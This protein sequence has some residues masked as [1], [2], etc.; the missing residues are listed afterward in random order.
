MSH[1]G[2]YINGN[3]DS[4]LSSINNNLVRLNDDSDQYSYHSLL[5]LLYSINPNAQYVFT[6]VY[7]PYKYLWLEESTASS[8]Y[9]DGFLGPLVWAIPD[10]LGSTV[11][12]AVRAAFLNTPAVTNLFEKINAMS[13]WAESFVTSLNDIIQSKVTSFDKPN[14]I[15]ADT[16][17]VFDPVPDRPITS[18]YHYND[19]VNVEFTKGYTVQDADWE[20]FWQGTDWG[21]IL[22]D[23]NS[24]ASVIIDSIVNE[25]ILPDVDPHPEQYGHYA[26]KSSFVDALGWVTLPRRTITFNANGGTGTMLSQKVVALDNMIACVNLQT[27]QFGSPSIGY[28]LVGWK[29]T[30]GTSYT[31]GQLVVLNGDLVLNAQWSNEYTLTLICEPGEGTFSGSDSD[32]G[33]ISYGNNIYYR[34]CN[35]NSE[36]QLSNRNFGEFGQN[37]DKISVTYGTQVGV[38]LREVSDPSGN[39]TPAI[40]EN[41]NR[42]ESWIS[43]DYIADG[44][45][46]Y[47]FALTEDT[48]I[49]FVWYDWRVGGVNVTGAAYWDCEITY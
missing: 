28:H 34:A 13:T 8:D 15:V 12:N 25:V 11:A 10:S 7:N 24:I 27:S 40:R 37:P 49:K 26:L 33:A 35:I 43:A 32:T 41:G 2:D 18:T 20:Q 19:L 36:Q 1:L 31:A 46:G 42:K 47:Q 3:M 38:I 16:K 9:K 6:T 5:S 22:S 29:D 45:W 44:A 4:M 48:T 23:I 39:V 14:F 17:A 21:A 30:N